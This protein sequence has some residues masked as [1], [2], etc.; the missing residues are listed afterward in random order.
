M[1]VSP[2]R[3]VGQSASEGCGNRLIV[4]TWNVEGL[5]D[6]KLEQILIYM[7]QNSLDV[8]CIQEV[9]KLKSDSFLH[10]SGCQIYWSGSGDGVREWAGVGFIVSKRLQKSVV[11]FTPISNRICC[12]R[13]RVTG[14]C[15]ALFSVYAPHNGKDLSE[16][17]ELY[18][19]L[20]HAWDH[21]SA[22]QGKYIMGDLNA[23]IGLRRPGEE[24]I[25][26]EFCFGRE[27]VHTVE[28]PNRELLMEF[29]MSR[30]MVV[31]NS[32][33]DVPDHQRVTYHEPCMAPCSPISVEGFAVLDLCLVPSHLVS[34]ILQTYSDRLASL[35]SHH[36]PV[37][38]IIRVNVHKR[39][40]VHKREALDWTQL[41]VPDIRSNFLASLSCEIT[42]ATNEMHDLTER[43]LHLSSSM[44][45][46]AHGAL[47]NV[48]R[49]A[50]KPWISESTL[51]LLEL[52]QNAR[53]QNDW[54]EEQ[55]LR[56]E[57][58][59]S[60]KRDRAKWLDELASTGDW[61]SLKIL[62]GS[63]TSK[64]TRLANHTG[65]VVSTEERAQTFARHL[66]TYQW[67]ERDVPYDDVSFSSRKTFSQM[68]SYL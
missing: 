38:S 6:V 2:H 44:R 8:V 15:L 46:A 31:A 13:V 40:V 68:R 3:L 27:A 9:R 63:C 32:L 29:C 65:D 34:S 16:R 67:H 45:K 24:H 18:T 48:K 39:E 21:A 43:W 66:E 60:A 14:G 12:L 20:E 49:K 41:R 57:V 52:K 50:K 4:C 5:T 10:D 64:Q 35:A 51:N 25:L 26:G 42:G 61:N 22:N 28:Q 36:F 56:K 53:V 1:G 33:H 23:R 11:G 7:A 54:M 59:R 58:K 19:S 17:S 62:K 30:D 55:C 37:I 47:P